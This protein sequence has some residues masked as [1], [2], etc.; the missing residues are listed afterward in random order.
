MRNFFPLI[1]LVL[2]ACGNVG[3]VF[4]N[5]GA[6]NRNLFQYQ[7]KTWWIYDRPDLGRMM[8]NAPIGDAAAAG[9]TLGIAGPQYPSFA[10][11]GAAFLASTDRN[12]AMSEGRELI[13]QQIEFQY[14]C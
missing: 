8:V 11:A 1:F 5:Y 10:L 9:A 14:R 6:D 7:G 3:Y 2:T 12:C 13:P 4:D